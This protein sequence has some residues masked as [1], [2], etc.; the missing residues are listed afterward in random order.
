[1]KAF[2]FF[3]N[4]IFWLWLFIIPAGGFGLLGYLLYQKSNDNL[5][6]VI[7]IGIVGVVL[8][9]ALAEYVRRKLGL[10]TFFG[11]IYK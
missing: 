1:M 7:L 9:V 5:L 2:M 10:S 11:S 4:L 6:Y 3:I 8:G